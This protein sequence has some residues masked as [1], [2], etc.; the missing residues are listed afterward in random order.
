[1]KK[2]RKNRPKLS[3][4]IKHINLKSLRKKARKLFSEY[5]R[6]SEKGICFTCGRQHNWK[7]TDCGHYIHRNCL[8]FDPIGNHCQ[9]TYCN[10][11]LHGNLGIY[12]ERLIAEYGEQAIIDLRQRANKEKKFTILEL[13]ELITKYQ[14]LLTQ[15]EKVK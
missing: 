1:M 12:A 11:F 6:K 10:R 14:T 3:K 4:K 7:E 9:C 5:T 2:H 8:D 13:K 15:L